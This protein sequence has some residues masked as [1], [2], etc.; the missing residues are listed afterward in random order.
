[1][2]KFTARQAAARQR[3]ADAEAAAAAEEA[4]LVQPVAVPFEV[5]NNW[6]PFAAADPEFLAGRKAELERVKAEMEKEYNAKCTFSPVL[7]TKQAGRPRTPGSRA[8]TPAG[9][10]AKA[11]AG[12]A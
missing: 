9:T 5:Y 12:G 10:P 8:G 11:A 3:R 6:K 1:M 7:A 2:E 4:A